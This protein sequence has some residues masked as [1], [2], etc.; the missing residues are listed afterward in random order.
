[1][2]LRTF[3]S[4][5]SLSG[6]CALALLFTMTSPVFANDTLPAGQSLTPGQSLISANGKYS[7][8]YQPDGNFV[9]YSGSTPLWSSNTG[10][11]TSTVLSMQSDGNLVI[12]NGTSPVWSSKTS[13]NP[14][15]HL[16]MQTDG[17]LVIYEA[18]T[19]RWATNTSQAPPPPP[20][21]PTPT[22]TPGPTPNPLL[23]FTATP[24]TVVAGQ[25]QLVELDWSTNPAV[26]TGGSCSV[27]SVPIN[28]EWNGPQPTVG[29]KQLLL[30]V[31]TTFTLLCGG[32]NFPGTTAQVTVTV[33]Q[34]TSP[35]L[36]LV[37][38]PT[39]VPSGQRVSLFWKT[40]LAGVTCTASSQPVY[41]AWN[42]P[43][44]P[45]DQVTFPLFRTTTFQLI[46]SGTDKVTGS[47]VSASQQV[48][49]NVP[50]NTAPPLSWD[51]VVDDDP[52]ANLFDFNGLKFNPEWGWQTHSSALLGFDDC[53]SVLG[54]SGCTG[55]VPTVDDPPSILPFLCASL[56]SPFDRKG[57]LNWENVSYYGQIYWDS[58]P[59]DDDYTW[60][61]QTRE[62]KQ[63]PAGVTSANPLRIHVEFKASE[64]MDHFDNTPFWQNLHA[65]VDDG[66][67]E[68]NRMVDGKNAIVMG[69]MGLDREH[70][71][72]SE[73][74][75]VFVFAIHVNEDPSD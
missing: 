66:N 44:L 2:K 47:P 48:T 36:T 18:S 6:F 60:S 16:L 57:H 1:M 55:Q 70:N 25:G 64:T 65:A 3:L 46:C 10:G 38:S 62:T 37:A 19:A 53:E 8:N 43:L 35:Y 42:G 4:A 74:H 75:P 40:T 26:L 24:S 39:T 13:G 23:T 15:S 67:G 27:T 22:P 71:S 33:T 59:F 29:K 63:Y 52:Q 5:W 20:P 11:T 7:A 12:Y 56:G 49:V 14:N 45:N 9:V 30:D 58:H 28:S 61:L 51:V 72:Q 69:L 41:N 73:I 54:V 68:A 17:N 34:G 32:Q 31:T 50:S 21:T